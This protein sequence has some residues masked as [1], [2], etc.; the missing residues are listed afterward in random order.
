[1]SDTMDV[2]AAPDEAFIAAVRD[3]FQVEPEIDRV[4]TRK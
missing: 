3:T 1:M 2:R 4:L